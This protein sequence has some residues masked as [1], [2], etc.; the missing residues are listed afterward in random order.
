[1]PL[2]GDSRRELVHTQD[3]GLT[4][5]LHRLSVLDYGRYRCK[6]VNE[7]HDFEHGIQF[8]LER[9]W[10]HDEREPVVN[11]LSPYSK[12]ARL[13]CSYICTCLHVVNSIPGIVGDVYM[14][15]SAHDVCMNK[16]SN[17]F[18]V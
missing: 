13:T 18:V 6:C 11:L 10:A 14:H 7:Q 1:M 2:D 16:Y 15:A 8:D 4:L 17:V 12:M 9:M 3:C 5:R